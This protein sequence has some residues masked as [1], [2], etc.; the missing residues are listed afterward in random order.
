MGDSLNVYIDFIRTL[1]K[2]LRN[3]FLFLIPLMGISGLLEV[4]SIASLIPLMSIVM[5]PERVHKLLHTL[6]LDN[7]NYNEAILLMMA[8]VVVI[9]IIKSAFGMYVYRRTFVFVA[10]TKV[11]A[12]LRLY[13]DYLDREYSYHIKRNSADYLRNITTECNA[14]ESRFIMPVLILLAELIPLSF[15]FI[16]VFYLNPLG[17]VIS[18]VMFVM[19]GYV[20][21]KLTSPKL[22]ELARR[23]LSSD[24]SAIKTIQQTF[25]SIREII[26]YSRHDTVKD[27]FQ[28][29]IKESADSISKALFINGLPR[30][31]LEI[32]A[33][34]CVFSI[35]ITS[36]LSGVLLKD[37]FI[38]IGIFLATL[39]KI[40]PSSSKI[41]AHFQAL[42]YAKPSLIN[43]LDSLN[44]KKD[45]DLKIDIPI[46]TK[47]TSIGKFESLRFNHV[48]L[49]Y[50]DQ[51]IINDCTI[52]IKR[53]DAIGIVGETGAGKSTLLN[54]ILG[55]IPATSG[56]I[57]VNKSDISDVIT[58]FRDKIGYVPQETYLLDDSI[59]NNIKFH[60]ELDGNPEKKVEDLIYKLGLESII[61]NDLGIFTQVG[62]QGRRISGGQRQR[63][64]IARALFSDPE[65]LIFDEATSALD[66]KTESEII[67][68]IMQYK[69]NKTLIMIA[70]R[71]STLT[72]CDYII[73]VTRG[74]SVN[75][76][77]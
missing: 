54:L 19:S 52:E 45:Q 3:K 68:Y 60:R 9:F 20:I 41:V 74:M 15:L 36:F 46:K 50:G 58:L 67:D 57:L 18:L 6:R 24:G 75:R 1:P 12:Q 56:K 69:S 76:I 70:H 34:I 48:G 27:E 73:R 17:L 38:E 10:Q 77:H 66:K 8:G 23:Q 29:H 64:G 72:C 44:V 33:I 32:V 35:A 4:A 39:V 53:G 21:T 31:F 2:R 11:S 28:R 43:Y 13:S 42:S 30:Y 62:E 47:C 61:D 16:F 40:L 26:I 5:E 59:Y 7:L 63:L 71:E 14:L 22:K 49:S 51:K 55:L 65:I 25:S 37:I